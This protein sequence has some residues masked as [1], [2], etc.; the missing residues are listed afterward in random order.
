V[1]LVRLERG[2]LFTE[3]FNTWKWEGFVRFNILKDGG[4]K[5]RKDWFFNDDR[6]E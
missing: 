4:S 3:G 1:S 5:Y 6:M 2:K